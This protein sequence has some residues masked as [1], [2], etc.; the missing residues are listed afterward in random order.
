MARSGA[1]ICAGHQSS[2][3]A[4]SG[5]ARSG[6]PGAFGQLRQQLQR[7]GPARKLAQV[8]DG[9][10]G[11]TQAFLRIDQGA[12]Q[13]RVAGAQQLVAQRSAP[14][15]HRRT[16]LGASRNT[17]S[18]GMSWRARDEPVL[19]RDAGVLRPLRHLCQALAPSHVGGFWHRAALAMVQASSSLRFSRSIS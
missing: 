7:P 9:G 3:A 16:G 19:Q 1:E 8:V 17:V 2:A 5:R 4:R 10:L 14:A 11:F 13:A 18:P 6:W 12:H 15:L